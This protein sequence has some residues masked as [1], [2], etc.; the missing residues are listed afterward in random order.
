MSAPLGQGLSNTVVKLGLVLVNLGSPKAPTTDAAR[1]YLAEFLWDRRVVEMPRALWWPILHL[2]V[3]RFRPKKTAAAY[4]KIW[5]DQG[6]PLLVGTQ[7]VAEILKDRLNLMVE[8]YVCVEVAMRY[9]APAIGDALEQMRKAGVSRIILLPLYPQYSG[10]TTASVYDALVEKFAQWRHIPGICFISDYH[11]DAGY[12]GAIA[13]S[14]THYWKENGK[15]QHL[16]FSFH[17]LPEKSRELGDPYYEQCRTTAALIAG[18][19]GLSEQSW[20]MV[21]QSRFG[22]AQWLKPYCVEVL[23]GLPQR[24]ITRVDIVCPGF[25]VDCLETLEEIAIANKAL[26]AKAG[27]QQYRYIPA[28][29]VRESHVRALLDLILKHVGHAKP[30]DT[31][32]A[33]SPS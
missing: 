17:G 18:K 3:L 30:C 27:G 11:D 15:P 7:R 6:S 23:A 4:R 28:L 16:L 33:R 10:A 1:R 9:G 12:I 19:I 14:V 20:Q 5:T 8:D 2:L 29:N 24:G 21:F 25:P 22:R 32:K 13:E 31:V 26:F